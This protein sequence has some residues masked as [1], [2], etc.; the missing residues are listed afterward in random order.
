M[1]RGWTSQEL[2]AV[3]D[4]EHL[5]T[6]ADAARHLG[7]LPGDPQDMPNEATITKL[8][9]LARYHH[10][11][12]AGK[13]R[14]SRPGKPGRFARAYQAADFIALYERMDLDNEEKPPAAA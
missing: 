12:P 8:R 9:I 10:L 1:T 14:S 3:G 13:R 6:I 2:D 4:D 11:P 5:W 7:P